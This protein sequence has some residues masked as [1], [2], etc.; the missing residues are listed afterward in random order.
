MVPKE[1]EGNKKLEWEKVNRV[2]IDE[3]PHLYLYKYFIY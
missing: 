3:W 2:N 1:G